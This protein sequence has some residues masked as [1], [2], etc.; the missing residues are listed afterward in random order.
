MD[1]NSSTKQNEFTLNF[2]RLYLNKSILNGTHR[3]SDNVKVEL[4]LKRC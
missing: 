4:C 2:V 3:I 1:F